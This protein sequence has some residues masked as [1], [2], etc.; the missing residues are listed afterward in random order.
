MINAPAFGGRAGS[1]AN[2]E[3]KVVLRNQ[4]SAM[5]SRKRAAGL[6]FHVTDVAR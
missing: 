2:Y 3:E 5:D 1:F 6:L 4:I